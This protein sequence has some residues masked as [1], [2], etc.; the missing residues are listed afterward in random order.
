MKAATDI[1]RLPVA[2]QEP[3]HLRSV[4]LLFIIWIA[5]TQGDSTATKMENGSIRCGLF[6]GSRDLF[7]DKTNTTEQVTAKF[8]LASQGTT[9]HPCASRLSNWS[10]AL[11]Q[12]LAP[13]ESAGIPACVRRIIVISPLSVS[14]TVT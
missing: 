6:C 1:H 12:P 2:P 4:H 10:N 3:D 14:S 13:G 7:E 5:T 11:I 8:R 9:N